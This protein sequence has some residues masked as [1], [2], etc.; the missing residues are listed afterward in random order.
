MESSGE[1]VCPYF[2]ACDEQL[3]L[4]CTSGHPLMKEILHLVQQT[5]RR[6]MSMAKGII[7]FLPPADRRSTLVALQSKFIFLQIYT[8][9]II[10]FSFLDFHS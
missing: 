8:L 5:H 2:S 1:F 4:R 7:S 6:S 10:Y 9:S 3:L